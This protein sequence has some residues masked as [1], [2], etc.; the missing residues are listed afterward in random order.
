MIGTGSE[1]D[2]NCDEVEDVGR[3][4]V[5]WCDDG[6]VDWEVLWRVSHLRWVVLSGG[7]YLGVLWCSW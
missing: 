4:R 1:S 3:Q 7:G 2:E 6:N 5:C